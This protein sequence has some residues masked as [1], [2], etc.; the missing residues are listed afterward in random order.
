MTWTLV[1]GAAKGVG[2]AI[3]IELAKQGCNLVVHY[4]KSAEK[5]EQVVNICKK[6]GVQAAS[7][8]GDFS[9]ERGVE[10][11]TARYLTTFKESSGLVNNVGNYL[12]K[13]LVATTQEEWN[14]L[15]QTNFFTPLFLVNSLSDV[16]KK[17]RGSVV[18]MGSV[19]SS[20]S[21]LYVNAAAYGLSKKML[22]Q[23]LLLY[24]KEFAPY[25]VRVNMV[26]PGYMEGT[27]DLEDGGVL[28]MGRVATLDEVAR[29]VS[30]FFAPENEYI[31][32]QNLEV[33]GAFGL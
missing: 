17:N 13:S 26:S 31:T 11:F 29:A 27:V 2:A 6:M 21:R 5:A 10:N 18:M 19:S 1:T 28:P 23:T 30:F 25:G 9:T 20:S 22:Y 4:N 33:A 24:A 14:A 16:L 15:L 7:I 32:G 12:A 3:C 8:Q